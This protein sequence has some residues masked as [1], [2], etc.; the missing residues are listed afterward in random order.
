MLI[1][2]QLITSY[3]A[4][5]GNAVAEAGRQAAG[6]ANIGRAARGMGRDASLAEKQ[7]RAFGTTLRYAFAGSVLFGMGSMVGKLNQLQQQMGLIAA[8]AG[9]S[10]TK[11]TSAF[12]LGDLQDSLAA[13]SVNARTNI[14][15]LNSSVINYLSTVQN[16]DP[17]E[18]PE[19]VSAIGMAARLSQTPTEDLT[20]AVTTLNIAAGRS[21]NLKTINALLR[22]WFSL[23]SSAPGGI[24]AAPQIAQQLGPL[25]SVA[26]M[27][28]LKPEQL[29][30]FSLASLRFGATPSVALRGTQFFLQSLFRPPSEKGRDAMRSAGLTPELLNEVGGTEF[31]RRYL[32]YVESIGGKPS[33][34]GVKKF[35]ALADTMMNPDASVGEEFAPNPKMS[36]MS[37]KAIEFLA[38][39]L[40]RIHGIRT[41]LVLLQQMDRKGDV[42]SLDELFKS[43]ENL[44]AGVGKE[45][46]QL[47]IAADKYRGETPLQAAAIALDSVRTTVA[48]DFG[49]FLN[50]ASRTIAG[51]AQE[52]MENER[53]RKGLLIGG[54]AVL[55]GGVAA[56]L[57]TK[58]GFGSLK[59]MGATGV[60]AAQASQAIS[61]GLTGLGE[62]PNNPVW[63]QLVGQ[64]F[65]QGGGGGGGNNLPPII[66]TGSK[67]GR[68]GR[69]AKVGG[70]ALT[71][72]WIASDILGDKIGLDTIGPGD[73]TTSNFRNN[74]QSLTRT[75]LDLT[76]TRRLKSLSNMKRK[77]PQLFAAADADFLK[78]LEKEV[79]EKYLGGE[80][81]PTQAETRLKNMALKREKEFRTGERGFGRQSTGSIDG[82]IDLNIKLTDPDGN[83]TNKKIEI[84]IPEWFKGGKVPSSRG[85]RNSV[86]MDFTAPQYRK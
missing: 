72:A 16:A 2:N 78:P 34:K 6:Y 20:K 10:G 65:G 25:A 40:G 50:P 24:A 76:R 80:V 56:R 15:D 36:G 51:G 22:E 42:A 82:Q 28:R 9:P 41:A 61:S 62:T 37:P 69:A 19:I 52:L 63:V 31:A 1:H 81:T 39:T 5:G 11:F 68:F 32:K 23:V 86:T 12:G 29:F 49:F 17:K 64:V 67:F 13:T 53:L 71:A 47:Q 48:R 26:Q 57:F 79:L 3:I 70:L 60:A 46:K 44:R 27:G 18:L 73:V 33:L 14:N 54:G 74:W 38:T 55:A 45:A 75:G 8:I 83:T 21:N 59:G 58:G 77:F 66:S 84:P 30:G 4:R 85:R 35:G 43:F 7:M